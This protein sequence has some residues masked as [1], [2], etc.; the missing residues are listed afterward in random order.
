MA[1]SP[2]F[3]TWPAR[4]LFCRSTL[5]HMVN[6][7]KR[8]AAGLAAMAGL[9]GGVLCSG[10]M[11]VGALRI[12]GAG[13]ASVGG[14]LNM[15]SMGSSE[16]PASVPEAVAVFLIS[17]GAPI[18]ALSI[19]LFAFFAAIAGRRPLPVV[20]AVGAGV[21]LFWG[22]YIQSAAAVMYGAIV[23]GLLVWTALLVLLRTPP[24]RET[25]A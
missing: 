21:L 5:E 6:G 18:L 1:I 7:G 11:I 8:V 13:A 14:A 23:V 25:R 3:E 9:L 24:R 17:W 22:M 20:L 15:G 12:V 10:A 16:A 4:V 2:G 19:A